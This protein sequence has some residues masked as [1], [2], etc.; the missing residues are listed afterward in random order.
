MHLDLSRGRLRVC[1]TTK[2][3]AAKLW[4]G[5]IYQWHHTHKRLVFVRSCERSTI[6]MLY[7]YSM[8]LQLFKLPCASRPTPPKPPTTFFFSIQVEVQKVARRARV[9]QAWQ[10]SLLCRPLVGLLLGRPSVCSGFVA[11]A[12]ETRTCSVTG[13]HLYTPVLTRFCLPGLSLPCF[14]LERREL[15][16]QCRYIG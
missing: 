12:Q 2:C 5:T 7:S 16:V 9:C 11:V 6:Y 13:W 4:P 8:H 14:F 10:Q 1:T 3:G 15:H